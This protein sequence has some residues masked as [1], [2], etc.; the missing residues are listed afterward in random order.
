MRRFSSVLLTPVKD[1]WKC[2]Y[3][4]RLNRLPTARAAL[5]VFLLGAMSALVGW[6]LLSSPSASQRAVAAVARGCPTP[7]AASRASRALG[8]AKRRYLTEAQGEVIHADLRQIA[9]DPILLG[10]LSA[11]NLNAA[12]AEADRQLVR[13]VVQIRVL[14][15][16]RVLLDANST[17]FDVGGAGLELHPRNG[18]SLGRLEI[19]VQ[20]VIGFIKLV[21]KLNAADVVV[22]ASGGQVRTSLP[23]AVTLSL[24]RAG[25][26]QIGTHRYVVSSFDETGFSG[27]RLTIRV[28]TAA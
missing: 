26:A 2:A 21:H 5:G 14:R 17:S 16:S 25:C 20:D 13:H 10:A 11:G 28:L 8:A 6:I 23:A 18:R 3:R 22:R 27:E 12:L 24:P 4:V 1:G 19:T 9:N 7:A 15:G